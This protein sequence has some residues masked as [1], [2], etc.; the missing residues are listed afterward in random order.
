MCICVNMYCIIIPGF[1]ITAHLQN[2]MNIIT[3]YVACTSRESEMDIDTPF[4]LFMGK[5]RN[6][7]AL[8]MCTCSYETERFSN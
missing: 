4:P 1:I 8:R 2:T 6:L 7:S 3:A 5:N